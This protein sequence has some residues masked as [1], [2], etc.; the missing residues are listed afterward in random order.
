MD[1]RTSIKARLS[2][3]TVTSEVAAPQSLVRSGFDAAHSHGEI[4][5]KTPGLPDPKPRGRDLAQ[6]MLESDDILLAIKTIAPAWRRTDGVAVGGAYEK[7][8]YADV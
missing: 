5:K 3:R 6:D 7:Q 1:A 2:G 8:S 4:F